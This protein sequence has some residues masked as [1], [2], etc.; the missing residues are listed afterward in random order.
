MEHE[1]SHGVQR[2]F[3]DSGVN[4]DGQVIATV[5][6]YRNEDGRFIE[7]RD[8]HGVKALYREDGSVEVSLQVDE[9]DEVRCVIF[10]GMDGDE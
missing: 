5:S 6:S 7:V 8:S 4:A 9:C 10:A 2:V 3:R 1:D